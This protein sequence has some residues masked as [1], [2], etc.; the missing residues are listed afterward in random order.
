MQQSQGFS[1]Q[2]SINNPALK[3]FNT[4]C[5]MAPA[6][7]VPG[8][9]GSLWGDSP[10]GV[11]TGPKEVNFDVSMAKRFIVGHPREAANLEFRADW[12]NALNHPQFA[13]PG[14][15][16]GSS[17]FGTFTGATITNPRIIQLALR[18]SF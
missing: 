15:T 8:T 10:F 11:L 5:F 4:G 18:Y 12:F 9:A 17:T 7:L 2:N 14:T 6:N 1:I 3:Y 16:F 13:D